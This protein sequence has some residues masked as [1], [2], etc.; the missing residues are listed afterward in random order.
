MSIAVVTPVL[1]EAFF[2]K[3]WYHCVNKFADQVIVVDTGSTDGTYEW[4]QETSRNNSK[5][6]VIRWPYKEN[7]YEWNESKIRNFLIE[8]ASSQWIF[9]LDADELVDE[10][11]IDFVKDLIKKPTDSSKKIY[12]MLELLFWRDMNH[13]RKKSIKPLFK[14]WLRNKKLRIT[15]I[16]AWRGTFPSYKPKLFKKD[17]HI[18]YSRRRNHCI[19]QY[20]RLGRL[21]HHISSVTSDINIPIYH[22]HFAFPFGK[23][24]ENRAFE[25]N[26][27][28]ELIEYN[29]SHPKEVEFFG[30]PLYLK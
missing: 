15:F 16:P 22:Y 12:R 18:S 10:T 8:C 21:S 23:L 28:F 6:S 17:K 24:N 29:G 13:L 3:A 5:L 19:L 7:P 11:F 20:K 9:A 26:R 27:N 1:N 4:L 30:A 14:I 25:R 2:I